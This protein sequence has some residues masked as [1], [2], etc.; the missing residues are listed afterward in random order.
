[1]NVSGASPN[2]S[3]VPTVT[4]GGGCADTLFV[5]LNDT[6][7]LNI[8][9]LAP[10]SDQT[11][12]IGVSEIG[13]LTNNGTYEENGITY[14][15]AFLA[16]TPENIGVYDIEITAT[17]NGTPEA[18]TTLSYVVSVIDVELPA[19]VV[20][21]DL[22]ICS[23]Q[24]TTITCNDD[25]DSYFWSLGCFEAE[26][27]YSFGGT[28]SVTASLD[29]GCSATQDFFID[30]SLYFLPDVCIE[31][32]PI[33]G[34]DTAIVTVCDPDMDSFVEY[35][36]DGDWNGAGGEIV[37]P[38][39]ELGD[40]AIGVTPGSFRILITNDDGCQGQRVFNV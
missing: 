20:E 5:C 18:E 37:V 4:P 29:V 10:E 27:T 32:N 17:D 23:G 30:Q 31:P 34:D 19:L 33:C 21:G 26:C 7:D 14:L 38:A 28:F 3:P 39:T 24:E 1:M 25:F 36:W 12:T 22:S 6:L 11:V 15:D 40:T 16:G 13:A 2:Q 35:E 9:F 8:G